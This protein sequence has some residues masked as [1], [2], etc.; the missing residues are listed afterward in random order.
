MQGQNGGFG[1][2]IVN[3]FNP[4][5]GVS[6]LF[7]WVALITPFAP[8]EAAEPMV[9]ASDELSLLYGDE[10][11]VSIAT[12]SAKPIHLAPAVTSVITTEEMKSIG[13]TRLEDALVLVPGLYV[14]ISPFNRLNP[15]WTM[16]GITSDQTPHVLLLR[17]GVPVTY[18][19]NGARPNLFLLP[20]EGID[21]VEVIRGPASAV[22]GAD[23]FAGVINVITK[24]P[25]TLASGSL[26]VRYGTFDT[27]DAWAQY[28]GEWAGWDIGFDIE[29]THSDG[30]DDRR[31]DSDLQSVFDNGF[32]TDASHAP[33]SLSTNHEVLNTTLRFKQEQ[34]DLSLW[35]WRNMDTG[36]GAGASQTLDPDGQQQSELSQIDIGYRLRE[37]PQDWS[38]D[39]RLS[40]RHLHDHPKFVLFPPGTSLPIGA[41]GNI[42]SSPLGGIVT[43]PDGVIAHLDQVEKFGN[44]DWTS[45]YGGWVGH[46]LRVGL[47]ITYQS[48]EA[49]EK[50]NFGPGVIDGSE[51]SVDGTLIDVSDTPYVFMP[52]T[53]RTIKYLSLQDVWNISSDWELTLGL[54]ADD[55]SDFGTT[56]NPRAALV[57]AMNY[58]LTSKL[59]Y[60]R[61]FR[62]P[63]F[64]EQHVQNNPVVL[65]NTNLDP[66]T[67]DSY[68]IAFDYRHSATLNGKLNLFHYQIE[69]LIDYLPDTAG[70][71]STAQNV[72]D[73]TGHGV[74]LEA[75]WKPWT[76]LQIKASYAWQYSED[77]STGQEIA[78]TPGQMAS[79][80][81][82]WRPAPAWTLAAHTAWLADF[83]REEGDSRPP[84]DD[85]SLTD[86]TLAYRVQTEPL[87]LQFK[88]SNLFDTDAR[89]PTLY[90]PNLG[91]A[92]IPSD[93]PLP[94]RAFWISMSYPL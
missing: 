23:A 24:T 39:L 67:I 89:A 4:S 1:V 51:G 71:T 69:A 76:E 87:E 53:Q 63:S 27:R 83:L 48:E 55:Y 74:E 6:R 34:W 61:A 54:R 85:Y 19:Y 59:L 60:G 37:L 22:Y 15:N 75:D 86:L 65:G 88:V 26:G 2:I 7:L 81:A 93:Y 32:G 68:E 33:G 38:S 57:W 44:L 66:E 78:N 28:G 21:H 58:N 35:H 45:I 30:D 29:Y 50:K 82:L 70:T 49:Q 42:G 84:I 40:A 5:T 94:G 31:V 62:A 17:D 92:A 9:L 52:Y 12:G 46:Q 10:E 41:D 16:R 79:I 8:S 3:Y 47:G 11:S 43:F 91:T 80:L 77:R 36:V 18:F 90:K 13:A 73:R 20:V 64:G 72:H 56:Y 14:G 25:E